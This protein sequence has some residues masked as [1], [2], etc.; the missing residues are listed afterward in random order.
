MST[1]R[2]THTA[3]VVQLAGQ[4]AIIV[5]YAIPDDAP[6]PI[7][8]GLARRSIVNSGQTCPCGARMVLPNRA[9]R[10][11]GRVTIGRIE[12]ED[13][14]PAIDDLLV[15]ALRLWMAGGDR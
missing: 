11:A 9:Q 6:Q 5:D 8:E 14:C 3:R 4:R 2:L 12:H 15:P 7:R 10:R 13:D 1:H